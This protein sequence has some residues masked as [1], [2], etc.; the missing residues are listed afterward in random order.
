MST[1]IP[2]VDETIN[3]I[4]GC[5]KA[6]PGCNSC[7]AEGMARRLAA[8]GK[9]G[10]KEVVTDNKWNGTTAFVPSALDKPYHWRQPRSIFIGSMGDVFHESV[11]VHWL[12]AIM[13]MIALNGHH[14]FILLTKRAKWMQEY[15]LRTID[16]P[17]HNLIL[18][19]SAENQ[20]MADE[21]IP[22][23]LQTPAAKRFVSLEPMVGPIVLPGCP[24]CKG[25]GGY[26]G[27]SL[28]FCSC[29]TCDGSP[30]VPLDGVILG[31][32]SG[33]NARR[34]NSAWVK[35]V[36]NQCAEANDIPFMFKQGSGENGNRTPG[37]WS[38]KRN[39]FPV[40]DGEIHTEL[41]WGLK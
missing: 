10:Y 28:G 15:M 22:L 39:G 18:G 2:W 31:G 1:G 27:A 35:A 16:K 3:P 7:Y 34:L 12:D 6:S 21:R 20:Q 24:E 36:R 40:L 14:T 4:I 30:F 17:L 32:E 26:V 5:S 19:V 9:E 37:H 23:L 13:K 33:G 25:V 8:M 29:P 41:A 11:K 38:E